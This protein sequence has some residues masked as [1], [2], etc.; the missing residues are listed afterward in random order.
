MAIKAPARTARRFTRKNLYMGTA[1]LAAL[2]AA[3]TGT[4]LAGEDQVPVMPGDEVTAPAPMA[5]PTAAAKPAPTMVERAVAQ[6]AAPPMMPTPDIA[7][8]FGAGATYLNAPDVNGFATAF[9]DGG[10]DFTEQSDP[11][12][13]VDGFGPSFHGQ[14]SIGVAG[15]TPPFMPT[16]PAGTRFNISG[17]GQMFSNDDEDVFSVPGGDSLDILAVSGGLLATSLGTSGEDVSRIVE[18]DRSAY[19]VS[20][21][22]EMPLMV[23]NL[24]ANATVEFGLAGMWSELDVSA[25]YRTSRSGR[26]YMLNETASA[27]Y[28]GP[29]LGINLDRPIGDRGLRGIGGARIFGFISDA[30]FEAAQS[31]SFSGSDYIEDE[32]NSALG[33]R[34][35]SQVGVEY[36]DGQGAAIGVIVSG[37]W[38]NQVPEIVNPRLGSGDNVSDAPVAFLDRED[39]TSWGVELNAR[40]TMGR[41]GSLLSGFGPR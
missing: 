4:A 35:D 34:I 20:T 8:E 13:Q 26:T 31:T 16:M 37:G 41:I 21:T 39:Q 3:T 30:D 12:W 25:N 24:P 22:L 29:V 6:L 27:Y 2:T 5:V 23:P 19:M 17:S 40:I 11:D 1:A 28:L 36:G 38:Q 14:I 15:R 9:T 10:S 18:A 33:A 7:F 32:D